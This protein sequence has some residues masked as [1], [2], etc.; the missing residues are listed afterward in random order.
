MGNEK[1]VKSLRKQFNKPVF[2]LL[3]FYAIMNVAVVIA[4][5]LQG[6]FILVQMVFSG[7]LMPE[8]E[9][10]ELFL[11]SAF[12]NGWGYILTYAVGAIV[13]LRWKKPQFCFREIWQKKSKMTVLKMLILLCLMT[14]MQAL[15]EMGGGFLQWF[16]G[17][18]G[19]EFDA[20][21]VNDAVN[22]N[23]FSMVFYMGILAPVGEEILFRGLLLRSLRP[24][25][26][27]FCILATAVLFG[28]FHGNLL[29]SGFAFC[30]GLI[31]GYVTVEYSM[32]WS[33]V[34]HMFN[35]LILCYL[36]PMAL[37]AVSPIVT[38]VVMTVLIYGCAVGSLLILL[39]KRSR[40]R[41]YLMDR[42][43]HP[44][45]VKGFFSAPAM[46]IFM[47]MMG[48]SIISTLM[49]QIG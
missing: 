49:M 29:Q 6:A 35:N 33:I 26:K 2:A 9:L 37:D 10:T 8:E 39:V 7:Q 3:I 30:V 4:V 45:C 36:L 25:G 23:S 16:F 14:A 20:S 27:K 28:L 42:R 34:L 19:L 15:F 12:S 38:Q 13:L 1:I 21:A 46:I 31:L 44:L 17:L 11:G 22:L 18:L 40:V 5:L 32:G 43:I 24:Y 41:Q 48:F 47:C